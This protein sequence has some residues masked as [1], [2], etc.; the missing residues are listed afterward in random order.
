MRQL[1]YYKV[2]QLCHYERTTIVAK[3]EDS[4][5]SVTAFLLKGAA[6][7]LITECDNFY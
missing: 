3:S 5:Q 1:T 7:N 6:N 2:R 4:V